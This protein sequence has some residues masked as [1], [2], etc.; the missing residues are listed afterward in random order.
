[1]QIS[2]YVLKNNTQKILLDYEK[3]DWIT[4]SQPKDKIKS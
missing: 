3:K 1:M 2:D 4:Q